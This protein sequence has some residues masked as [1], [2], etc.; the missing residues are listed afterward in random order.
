[1]NSSS[2]PQS[3]EDLVKTYKT[4]L[5]ELVDLRPSG[6]RQKIAETLGKHK[7][8]VSQITN[9]AYPVPIPAGDV[10]VI[11]KVCH[12]SPDERQ[13]FLAAY[14]AAHPNRTA[15]A[16]AGSPRRG[17]DSG[18]RQI[19]ISLPEMDDPELEQYLEETIRQTARRLISLATRR[20]AKK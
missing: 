16:T 18:G 1:M 15:N 10:P 17:A 11:V 13:R 9:P 14:A 5:R 6:T 8:F 19:T 20:R 12:L 3:R 7:S 2:N 4:L